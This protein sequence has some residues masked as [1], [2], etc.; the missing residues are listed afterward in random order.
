MTRSQGSHLKLVAS[1]AT[2]Y[3]GDIRIFV[4]SRSSAL[5][6]VGEK[7]RTEGVVKHVI[8]NRVYMY[9]Q[10]RQIKIAADLLRSCESGHKAQHTLHIVP[11]V[12]LPSRKNQTFIL[13]SLPS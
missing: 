2:I 11:W 8:I 13:P 10:I 12:S 6:K 4:H 1:D 3:F 5:N 9:T 7:G